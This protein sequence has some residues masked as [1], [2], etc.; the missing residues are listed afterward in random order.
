MSPETAAKRAL[1]E[2]SLDSRVRIIAVSGPGEPLAN[3]ETFETFELLRARLKNIDYCLSTNGILLFE[4]VSWLKKIGFKTVSVSMSTD[5]PSS[6][7]RI[8]EW[9]DIQDKRRTGEE[10]GSIIVESQL[11]GIARAAGAGLTV[12]VNTI[13]IPGIN[14]DDIMGLSESIADAGAYIQNIVPLVPNDRLASLASPSMN[15]L[16]DIRMKASKYIQQFSH[17]KQCRS[18]VVGLPGHDVIL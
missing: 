17:C 15:D 5:V 13:L 3:S 7:A 16:I 18:D 9:A 4:Y 12:K 8:Y 11:K 6:A 1:A 2:T 14:Q 10:M